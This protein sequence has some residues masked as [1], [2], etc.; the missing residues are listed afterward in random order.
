[1]VQ[2]CQSICKTTSRRF[3]K[4]L[5]RLVPVLVDYT[6]ATDDDELRE[7]CIQVSVSVIN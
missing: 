4:H 2:T 3:V 1:M 7:S 6:V 5:S